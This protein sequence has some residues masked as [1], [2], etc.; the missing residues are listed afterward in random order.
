MTADM[1]PMKRLIQTERRG[2][3][4]LVRLAD[5]ARR[6]ALSVALVSELVDVLRCSR[7]AG[8]RALV[9][10]SAEKAFC[11]GAD[12]RD[13]LNSGWLD[14]QPGSDPGVT[15]LDLFE[16]IENDDRPIIAAVNG[17]ALGGG[18]EL[19]LACD[20][21]FAGQSASFMFPELAFGVLPN[22]AL[23]RLP[24][25]IGARAAADLILT[26][27]RIDAGEALRLKLVTE[28]VV[29]SDVVEFAVARALEIVSHVP[30]TALG[31]AKR[32]LHAG[33]NWVSIRSMLGEMDS[34]EWREGV[35]AFVEKR[36]PDFRRFWEDCARADEKHATPL[37]LS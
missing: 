23:A 7:G 34:D 14:A 27:R 13:M 9:L 28:L 35:T 4:M 5:S 8:V 19:C 18:V 36:P 12:I 32:I 10:A 11:A 24:G 26:R 22:T 21:V 25:L 30:P 33:P 37:R 6:N 29:G 20:L 16:A 3:V 1:Q 2:D 31:A 17:L 15:P